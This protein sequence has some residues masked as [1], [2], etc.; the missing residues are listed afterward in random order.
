MYFFLNFTING[1]KSGI[2]QNLRI[3]KYSK[4]ILFHMP[5]TTPLKYFLRLKAKDV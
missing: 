5:S 2:F 1:T 4:Q 3:Y